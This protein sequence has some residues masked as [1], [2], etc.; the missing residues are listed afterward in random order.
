MS[1]SDPATGAEAAVAGGGGL[2]DRTWL[3]RLSGPI[4]YIGL[5]AWMTQLTLVDSAP[6]SFVR[7]QEVAASLGGRLLACVVLLAAVHHILDGVRRAFLGGT[8]SRAGAVDS[9]IR[10]LTWAL[11]VPG[12]AVLLRPWL[13]GLAP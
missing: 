6:G 9:I 2:G 7:S 12:W 1:D 3:S 4:L 5:L 11:V 13:E 10:F 8:F